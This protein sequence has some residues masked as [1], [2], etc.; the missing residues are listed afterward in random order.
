MAEQ[1]K[2]NATGF[3]IFVDESGDDAWSEKRRI[4]D[5]PYLILCMIL[6]PAPHPYE[7]LHTSLTLLWQYWRIKLKWFPQKDAKTESSKVK[8]FSFHFREIVG[9]PNKNS[10]FRELSLQDRE[11]LIREWFY[12]LNWHAKTRDFLVLGHYFP[13]TSM[14]NFLDKH[15]KRPIDRQEWFARIEIPPD[16]RA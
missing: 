6:A 1:T 4:Q 14:N 16:V 5:S 10:R 12:V 3:K 2:K 15:A 13:K 7:E 9:K 8:L 11:Q